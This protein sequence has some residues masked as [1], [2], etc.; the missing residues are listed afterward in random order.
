[1]NWSGGLTWNLT[2]L[3]LQGSYVYNEAAPS[4]SNLG[5]AQVTT[6]NVTTYDYITGQSVL[7]TVI[8]GGNPNLL[9]ERRNDI[10]LGVNWTLPAS[11][12]GQCGGG[13]FQQP[14]E[15]RHLCLPHHADGGAGGGLSG[16]RAAQQRRAPSPRSTGARSRWPN[17]ARNASAGASTFRAIW[18]SR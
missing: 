17:S 8:T 16:A 7:A 5:A 10:K 13:I 6:Y 15:Q 9:R 4:L 3:G 2:K 11:R 1:V 14:L 12:H 18:A